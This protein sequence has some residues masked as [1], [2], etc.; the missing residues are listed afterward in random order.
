MFTQFQFARYTGTMVPALLGQRLLVTAA[1]VRSGIGDPATDDC[2]LV[3]VTNRGSRDYRVSSC[4]LRNETAEEAAA[5]DRAEAARVEA[6][7]AE[8]QRIRLREFALSQ[9]AR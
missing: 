2:C 1:H 9:G 5:A 7:C 3:L 4:S 8:D 6:A